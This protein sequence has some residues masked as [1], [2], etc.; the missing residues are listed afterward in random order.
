MPGK[1]RL[2]IGRGEM[3]SGKRDEGANLVVSV[4][5][6][7]MKIVSFRFATHETVKQMI[8]LFVK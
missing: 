5:K 6:L 8:S 3:N 2:N 4:L 7:L 1:G